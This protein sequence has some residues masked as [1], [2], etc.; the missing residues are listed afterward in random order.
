[1]ANLTTRTRADHCLYGLIHLDP[2]RIGLQP[3][4]YGRSPS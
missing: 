4:A 1:M 2:L 3:I